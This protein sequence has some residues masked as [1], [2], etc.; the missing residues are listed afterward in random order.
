MYVL[1]NIRGQLHYVVHL[2]IASYNTAMVLLSLGAVWAPS[3]YK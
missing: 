1:Y 2:N 3:E